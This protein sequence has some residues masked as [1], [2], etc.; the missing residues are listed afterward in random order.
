[1]TGTEVERVGA[2]LGVITP[3]VRALLERFEREGDLAFRGYGYALGHKHV[4]EM[5]LH[6]GLTHP[7][8]F[9][10]SVARAFRGNLV[11]T[12][13]ELASREVGQ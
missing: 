11:P 6:A 7:P 4:P 2:E 12:E 10:P 13:V 1:M 5:R 9:A 3:E 8:V